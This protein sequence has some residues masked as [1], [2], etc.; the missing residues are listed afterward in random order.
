MDFII[1]L[2][3]FIL[4]LSV[5]VLIHELGHFAT[6]KF[7]G[8]YCREFSLGMGP[9]IFKHKKK[10]GET[11][12]SIRAI[13]LGG[14]VSMVGEEAGDNA[15]IGGQTDPGQKQELTDEEK[16]IMSLPK[17]RRLDGIAKWK[18]AIIMAAG[19]IMNIVLA[20]VLFICMNATNTVIDNKY[21]SFAN[22]SEG[23][24]AYNAN[25]TPDISFKKGHVTY[26]LTYREDNV[27]GYFKETGEKEMEFTNGETFY[28]FISMNWLTLDSKKILDL[29]KNDVMSY[30][31]TSV[32]NVEYSFERHTVEGEKDSYSFEPYGVSFHT[33]HLNIG[34][35]FTHTF[36]N[37]GDSSLAI[38]KALG[39]L[40]TKEGL[41]SIGGPI[42][43]FQVSSA[44]TK[45][46]IQYYFMLWGLISVNLAIMN[47]LPIPGLD[48]WHFLV[49]I[50][51]GITKKEMPAKAKNIAS[52]V[53][54]LLLFGLMILVTIKDIIGLF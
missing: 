17:E 53:G 22:V 36:R 46:G 10:G 30:T 35:I 11:Q 23:S 3:I 48:G 40:F 29:S 4:S 27:D 38:Y 21:T 44:Y 24:V 47:F 54:L 26:S 34:E 20:F 2:I 8:V 18:R 19:V 16:F 5:L 42:A 39:T 33:R 15:M 31:L 28:D 51:E 49:L 52:T 50:V 43:I 1:N 9:L 25:I 41:D 37:I 12:F 14:F 32:D 45:M 13:P 6:A 7:F